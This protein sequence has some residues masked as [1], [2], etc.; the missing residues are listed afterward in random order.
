MKA[1]TWHGKR[2]VRIDDVPDPKIEQPTDA[3]IKVTSTAICGS[4]LHLYELFGPFLG[5]GDILG[6]EPMGIIEEVGSE[7]HHVAPGDRVVI[8]FNVSCGSCWMCD[9]GLQSQCETTQVHEHGTGASLL[10]YTKLYG[11]VP[12][13]QAEYLRVPQAHYGP[14]KVPEGTPDEQYLFLSDVL[15]TAYQGVE[16]ADVPPGGTVAVLGLGPIGQMAARIA[17]HRGASKVFGVD[18]VPERL[19]M[20]S[21]HGVEPVDLTQVD[22]LGEHLRGQTDGRG[23]DSVIDAVGMEAHGSGVAKLA[24]TL[25]GFLPDRIADP[26]MQKAGID[27]L[28]AL[29]T[30]V[31][32]VRRGGTLSISGVY[33]G[34]ADPLPMLQMFDKQ[35]TIRMG[36]ANVRRW[37]DDL[38][39]LL[40]DPSDPLGVLD[41]TTHRISLGEA[42]AA[43]ET[44][45]K[46]EDGAI[47]VVIEP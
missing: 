8:P 34:A 17:V 43:Y 5:E 44:F 36:Q 19:Q 39:P 26:F 20:A 28:A 45:Q 10:G 41:L 23:P 21:R 1:L 29:L 6:H 7:V 12:G 31:D 40:D 16:Y 4:D 38:M 13:G 30:G 25:V 46:K 47:K 18:L 15:P 27:R 42:P 24:Q 35:I 2:D 37:V 33:G 11:Q 3:I 32:A 22:D 9:R 14:I